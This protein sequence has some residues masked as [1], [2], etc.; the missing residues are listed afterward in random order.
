[1]IDISPFE[2]KI[3]LP[4]KNITSIYALFVFFRISSSVKNPYGTTDIL[5]D[6]RTD[7]TCNTAW[8]RGD[9]QG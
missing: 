8:L 9:M 7:K 4:R 3:F 1:M 6:K 2:I 5:V